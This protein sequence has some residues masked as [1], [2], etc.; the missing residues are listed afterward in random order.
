MVK[1]QPAQ[2][3][4]VKLRRSLRDTWV[5]NI[6]KEECFEKQNENA[7]RLQFKRR[8]LAWV[9]NVYDC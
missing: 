8:D 2:I 3:C 7:A 4:S 1:A 9:C 6:C 5:E